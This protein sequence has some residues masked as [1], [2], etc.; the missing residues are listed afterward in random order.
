[1]RQFK[2]LF[3]LLS[4]LLFTA[5]NQVVLI[6]DKMPG[7]T[8]PNDPI[9]VSGSFNN[10]KEGDNNFIVREMEDGRYGVVLPALQ[11]KIE[12]KFSRGNW[13]TVETDSCGNDI[14]N[15]ELEIKAWNE[16]SV[17]IDNWKDRSATLCNYVTVYV[18]SDSTKMY[19][20]D[21]LY[22]VGNHNNW[23]LFDATYKMTRISSNL[24]RGRLPKGLVEVLEFKITRGDWTKVEVDVSGSISSPHTIKSS[25]DSVFV[26]VPMW[27]DFVVESHPNLTVIV[28]RYPSFPQNER[29][30]LASNL[31]NWDPSAS[32]YAFEKMKNSD[33]WV[34]S[35]PRKGD[36]MYFKI[37]RGSWSTVET[38]LNG[39]DIDNR[40]WDFGLNDTAYVR[41]E[42]WKD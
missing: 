17:S 40:E 4:A 26:E 2:T 22:L 5:C 23:K 1:M 36:R 14:P 37:T 10:W 7:N 21:D 31:N 12:Y 25:I 27:N 30:Y 33:A 20:D 38:A 29:L 24:Y 42:A 32:D 41:V 8:P 11:G 16:V 13:L 15:R 9:F 18:Q 6:V 39:T 19:R 3:L 28:N 34:L 35:L